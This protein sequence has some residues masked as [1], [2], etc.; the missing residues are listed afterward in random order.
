VV[1]ISPRATGALIVPLVA[2]FVSDLALGLV[3][4]GVYFEYIASAGFWLVYACIA[5]STLL[6]F[7]LRGRVSGGRVLG[8]SLLGSVLF[9]LVTN[10]GTWFGGTMYPQNAQGLNGR[11][12]RG[13]S[14]LQVDAARHPGLFGAAVRRLRAAAPPRAGAARA[15][16][17]TIRDRHAAPRG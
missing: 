2:M 11:V 12:H 16:G 15:D 7:N 17:L 3:N 1:R 13:D 6:G 4:G 14:F 5:L 9:F 10:F 8:Y